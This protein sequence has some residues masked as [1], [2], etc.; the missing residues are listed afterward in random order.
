[1]EIGVG[2]TASADQSVQLV[3][4]GMGLF[5]YAEFLF[6]SDSLQKTECLMMILS[7]RYFCQR[8]TWQD[9]AWMEREREILFH[10]FILVNFLPVLHRK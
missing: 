7:T 4:G 9:R 3:E 2:T 10:S 6:L 8:S 5:H 1:M